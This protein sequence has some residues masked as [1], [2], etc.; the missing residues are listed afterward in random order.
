MV[1]W[2]GVIMDTGNTVYFFLGS[3][4]VMLI[5]N[6]I[7]LTRIEKEVVKLR[8]AIERLIIVEQTRK[9]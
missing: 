2:Y 4:V 1:L 5:S 3:F 6:A 8:A 9:L 7:V